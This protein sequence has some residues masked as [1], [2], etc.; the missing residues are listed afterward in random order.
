M[1]IQKLNKDFISTNEVKYVET[2]IGWEFVFAQVFCSNTVKYD[3][4]LLNQFL[5]NGILNDKV[6]VIFKLLFFCFG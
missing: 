4:Q 3:N 1:P 6:T 2:C 5:W